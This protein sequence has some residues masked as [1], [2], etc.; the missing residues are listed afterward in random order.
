MTPAAA[1]LIELIAAYPDRAGEPGRYV[2]HNGYQL[3]VYYWGDGPRWKWELSRT[4]D[5]G[6]RHVTGGL[7]GDPTDGWLCACAAYL[8]D[9]DAVAELDEVA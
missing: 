9:V 2:D 1:L 8:T 6:I 4:V 3:D 5:H 7:A